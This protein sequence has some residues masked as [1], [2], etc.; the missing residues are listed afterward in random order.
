MFDFKKKRIFA[1][2]FF[3]IFLIIIIKKDTNAE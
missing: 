1:L 2:N 3:N